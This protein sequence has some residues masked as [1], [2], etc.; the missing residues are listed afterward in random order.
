VA[1]QITCDAVKAVNSYGRAR[2]TR[3][4]NEK[5]L[6]A[7]AERAEEVLCA[8]L[9][10]IVKAGDSAK[11][12]KAKS[13]A[14]ASQ[15][16]P[17]TFKAVQWTLANLFGDDVVDSRSMAPAFSSFIGAKSDFSSLPREAGGDCD[18]CGKADKNATMYICGHAFCG[19]PDCLR[20]TAARVANLGDCDLCVNF[21]VRQLQP[22]CDQVTANFDGAVGI[23]NNVRE[24]IEQDDFDDDDGDGGD[25]AA[26]AS[27]A[28]DVKKIKKL[29]DDAVAA[30]QKAKKHV[31]HKKHSD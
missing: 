5:S 1:A 11:F 22:L 12:T 26:A 2:P 8:L 20:P 29:I 19:K 9:F 27:A 14:S 4:Y 17:L 7:H 6:N 31:K 21:F 13:K 30:L 23:D 10:D 25:G 3:R 16:A 24:A 18:W 28:G 15:G